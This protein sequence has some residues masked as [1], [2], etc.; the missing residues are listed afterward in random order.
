MSAIILDGKSIG[1]K[2]SEETRK[3]VA[4]LAAEHKLIPGLAVIIIGEDP[5]SKVYVGRKHK[6]CEA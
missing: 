3:A 4:L 6:A 2:I 1:E 5:A